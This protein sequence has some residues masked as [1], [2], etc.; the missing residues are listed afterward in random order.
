[1]GAVHSCIREIFVDGLPK[2]QATLGEI[3]KARIKDE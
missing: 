2:A 3:E 1:M